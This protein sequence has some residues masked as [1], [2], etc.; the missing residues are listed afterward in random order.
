MGLLALN[1][2][3]SGGGPVTQTPTSAAPG[4]ERVVVVVRG[5]APHCPQITC[6]S[7]DPSS[8]VKKRSLAALLHR[9]SH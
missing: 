6:F 8:L 1:E 3:A 7:S 5:A 4:G 9:K 2:S